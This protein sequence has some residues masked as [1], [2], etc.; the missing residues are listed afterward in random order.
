QVRG[1]VDLEHRQVEALVSPLHLCLELP[2]VDET[3]QYAVGV[4]DHVSIRHHVPARIDDEARAESLLLDVAILF[5]RRR[6]TSEN[7]PR[8]TERSERPEQLAEGPIAEQR[9]SREL[10]VLRRRDV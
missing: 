5:A 3:H 4:L 10:H 9:C 2:I 6:A 1:S 7:G 8:T